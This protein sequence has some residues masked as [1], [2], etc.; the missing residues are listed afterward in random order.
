MIKIALFGST[1]SIGTQV[2]NVVDRYPQ[3]YKIVSL[4][5]NDNAVELEKQI[6]KYKPSVAVITN[7]EKVSIIKEVG[8]TTLYWG[9]NSLEHALLEEADIVV[10]A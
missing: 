3:E 1:G 6:N 2:L 7:P 10:V 5:A 4:T 8:I 9:Q